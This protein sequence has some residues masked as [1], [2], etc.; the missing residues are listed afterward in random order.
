MLWQVL[1]RSSKIPQYATDARLLVLD[2]PTTFLDP[3]GQRA[4]AGLL[5]SLPQASILVT[6][7]TAFARS[8]TEEAVFFEE[9]RIAARGA[10]REIVQRFG[11]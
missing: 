5:A 7:D 10:I 8:L 6:H 9:G 3:P 1:V 4:L 11:W 2:E